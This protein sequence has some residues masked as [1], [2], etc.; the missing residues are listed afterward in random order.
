MP[1]AGLRLHFNENTA[2]C[3]PAVVEALRGL[4]AEDIATYPDYQSVAARVARWLNVAPDS[5]VLTNGLDEGLQVV[6]QFGAWHADA[7]PRSGGVQFI[8]VDPAFEMFEV[9]AGIVRAEVVRI[10]PADDFAFP[11]QQVLDAIGP[12]TRVIYLIDPNNPTG[13]PLPPGAAETIAVA[14]PQAIVLVD[15]AYAD[16][17][18]RTLIGPAL[19]R[20]PNIVVGRTFAKGHGL[21]GLRIGALVGQAATISRL[22]P[23]LPP[24][25][26]NVGAVRALEAA[27]GDEA[28]LRWSVEQAS[29]SRRRV[30]AFCD[31]L[32][33]PYWPGVGNF[34]LVRVGPRAAEITAAL[35]ARSIFVRD[36]SSAPG[37]AGCLRLTAGFVPHTDIMLSALEELLATRPN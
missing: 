24:F 25:N 21:A 13:L 20:C 22:R 4:T 33:L 28:Y 12:D 16:F 3:S 36:K 2:G 26:V 34:L 14:A 30:A 7:A 15:E 6:A 35:A 27:L 37:C 11:Q 17:S 8:Q 32:Q 5:V 23:I 19:D 18:G 31:R 9:F 10:A 1:A 29:E